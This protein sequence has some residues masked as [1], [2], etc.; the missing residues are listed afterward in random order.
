MIIIFLGI[1]WLLGLWIASLSNVSPWVWI[2]AGVVTLVLAIVFRRKKRMGLIFGMVAF[3]SF[4]AGRSESAVTQIDAGH[5]AHY[6]GLNDVVVTGLVDDEPELH[7]RVI[8]LKLRSESIKLPG[9][10]LVPVEGN[11]QV[12]APRFPAVP[13]GARLQLSGHLEAPDEDLDFDYR[14]Y[15]ARRDI[16]SQIAWPEITVLEQG[17]GN[18]IYHAI[19]DIK[20]QAQSTIYRILPDPQAALLSGILLGNDDEIPPDLEEQFR[21]SGLSHIIA[22]SGFNIAI[23]AG[24]LLAVSKPFL[25]H[26]RSAWFVL[27]GIALYTILVGADAAVVRA[28][29][30]GALFV[31]ATRLMG[32][33]TFAP[34]GL[35]TAA[36][37]MTLANPNI[38]WDVGFQL[39]FAATLGLMLFVGPWGQW[40]ETRLQTSLGSDKGRQLTRLLSEVVFATLAAMLFT[41]PIILFYFG[42]L[43]LVSPAANLFV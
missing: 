22:I 8:L 28:A 24:V 9:S 34:A 43:S 40:A 35:F 36:I 31:I 14:T 37:I 32:R 21:I 30:M 33:P 7:D 15:L 42:Q 38:L 12:V 27:A 10:E 17:M 13:Y 2:A 6:N 26:R 18:P 23:L 19:Y 4:G 29:I 41:L 20:E 25:G 5:I 1:A 39:S 16:Y 3:L 11:V